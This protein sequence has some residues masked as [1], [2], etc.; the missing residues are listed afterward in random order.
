MPHT[1]DILRTQALYVCLGFM[2]NTALNGVKNPLD[3]ITFGDL[4]L[5]SGEM[6]CACI[7]SLQLSVFVL[8]PSSDMLVLYRHL[9]CK[10]RIIRK[11]EIKDISVIENILSSSYR[12]ISVLD[13]VSMAD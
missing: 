12:S 10:L 6:Y 2:F 9:H 11:L 5:S 1:V 13:L 4:G 3:F 8:S 7:I